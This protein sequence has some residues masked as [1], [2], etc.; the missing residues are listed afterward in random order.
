MR[1]R[2]LMVV[3]ITFSWNAI[4]APLVGIPPPQIGVKRP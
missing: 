3:V 2:L 4:A 1:N